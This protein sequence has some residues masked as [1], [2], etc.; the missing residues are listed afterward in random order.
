MVLFQT[1]RLIGVQNDVPSTPLSSLPSILH[2]SHKNIRG[3]RSGDPNTFFEDVEIPAVTLRNFFPSNDALF[4]SGTMSEVRT[5]VHDLCLSTPR[6]IS[7]SSARR[8]LI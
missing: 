4:R 5:I 6:R 3:P 8:F 1:Y 7:M 2:S